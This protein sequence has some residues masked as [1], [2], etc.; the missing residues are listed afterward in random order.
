MITIRPMTADD[1]PALAA[2][3]VRS[4]ADPALGE[5]WTEPAAQ[6]LLA[7]WYARQP[8]LAFVAADDSKLLGAFVVGVRP[9]WDGNHLVDGE[10]FVD[11]DSQ[12]KGVASDLIREVLL[13]A[14]AK[15]APVVWESYTFKGQDFPLNWYKRMGFR[16]ID[17]WVMIR[18]DVADVLHKLDI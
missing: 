10:L 15:Y 18:A 5:H 8:D 4:F 12:G 6:A 13:Q 14:K 1:L 17:E 11:S 16:E 2:M 9:W 3:Y 7:N